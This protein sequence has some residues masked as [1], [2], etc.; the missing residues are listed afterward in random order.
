[1]GVVKSLTIGG[2]TDRHHCHS[3]IFFSYAKIF[4][5]FGTSYQRASSDLDITLL[6]RQQNHNELSVLSVFGRI[7]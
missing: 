1:V 5:P 4:G 6:A 3:G 7:G 2:G